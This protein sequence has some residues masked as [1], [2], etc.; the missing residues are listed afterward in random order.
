[1]LVVESYHAIAGQEGVVETLRRLRD[2]GFTFTEV[3]SRGFSTLVAPPP[4]PSQ[5]R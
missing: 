3:I 1:M 5:D 2:N 4:P